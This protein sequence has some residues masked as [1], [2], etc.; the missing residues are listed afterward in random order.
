MPATYRSPWMDSD[1]E[2]FAESVRR[3]CQDY[4]VP[5][6]EKWR[7]Q[8]CIDREAWR[9]AGELGMILPD[10]PMEYGGSGATPAYLAASSTELARNG[11]TSLGITISHIV[12][13]YILSDGTEVQKLHWLP[14]IASGEVISAVAMTEPGTGSDLQ[15]IRTRAVKRGDSY[16]INGAKTFI[17]NGTLCD[18]VAVV[19][20]TD[21]AA[22][23]KGI[24]IFLVD[25]R[26]PGF[27]RGKTLD[28][29]G[30][31]A[32]DTAEMYF[33]DVEVPAE[34]LLGGVEGRGF[35]TLMQQ[36]PYERAQIAIQATG[37]MELALDLTLEYTRER[38]V[39]GKPVLDFQ[40]TRHTL[41]DVKAT[42]LASR[43]LCDHL[44]QQWI[45][46]TLDS[47]LASM[48][49]FWLTERQGE[50]IDR[51]LQLFGGYGYMNE[52]PIARLYTESRITRIYG[53]TN[54]IQ[55]ELVGRSL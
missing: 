51:C 33:D 24:S 20:K 8:H 31:A 12:G 32:Q 2:A 11:C 27:R 16:V 22:G 9:K 50:V 23:A 7:R 35:Y 52:Y 49:K 42:V 54:E 39:F 36:L 6:D 28:K 4:L 18:M 45:A 43:T 37:S 55:R 5:N 1:V 3:F 53:G 10:V 41:A 34:C 29:L 46:G 30:W 25:T 40:T 26:L 44:V 19:A 21:A 47:T 14:R 17:S 15:A 48:C 13:H 38:Q